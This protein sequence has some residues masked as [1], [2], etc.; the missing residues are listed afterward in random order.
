MHFCIWNRTLTAVLYAALYTCILYTELHK[1][2]LYT[3][4]YTEYV[5]QTASAVGVLAVYLGTGCYGTPLKSAFTFAHFC[6]QAAG[7]VRGT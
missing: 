3:E 2:F 6:A 5:P 7:T 1:V 4:L